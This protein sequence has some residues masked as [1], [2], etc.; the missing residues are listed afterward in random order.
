MDAPLDMNTF[1]VGKVNPRKK[2][3]RWSSVGVLIAV[4]IISIY[5]YML[6]TIF[7]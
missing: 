5:A 4:V 2:I 7:K 1:V 6:I 3:I